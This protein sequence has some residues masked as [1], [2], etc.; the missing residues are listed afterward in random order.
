MSEE[1][2]NVPRSRK[3]R[4][5]RTARTTAGVAAVVLLGGIAGGAGYLY[6][7][8]VGEQYRTVFFPHTVVNGVDASQKTVDEVE[9][10]V[11]SRMEEDYELTVVGRGGVTETITGK[12]IGMHYE[13][14]DSLDQYLAAQNPMDWWS[15]R[16]TAVEYKVDVKA[17]PDEELLADR[18]D[19][20]VFLDDDKMVEP[21]NASLS[22]YIE[23]EGYQV[24]PEEEGTVLDKEKVK[25]AVTD[26][27][28][29]LKTE[30]VLEDLG[31]YKKA[32]VTSGDQSLTETADK[33]NRYLT[34]TV[35]YQF[36]DAQEILD[37]DTISG[38]IS[39]AEDGSILVDE[40]QAAAYV[41]GLAD[42]YDTLGKPKTLKTTGGDVVTITGGTFGWSINQEE[43]T[44]QLIEVIRS[45]E[46]Q[47]REPVY[48]ST[49]RSHGE[50]DYGDTYVEL[51]LTDQHMYYYKDGEMVLESDFVSGTRSNQNRATPTG[52]YFII[53]KQRDRVLR[54]ERRADG[55]YE[56]ESPV[57]YWMPF[58]GGVG[59]HDASWRGAFGGN[60][61]LTNGSHGCV[62]LPVSAAKE[63]YGLISEGDPVLVFTTDG[64][65]SS[66]Y[67]S[68]TPKPAADTAA[69][70]AIQ[71]AETQP[72]VTPP[73]EVQ[74][75]PE[76]PPAEV[77]PA[78][79]EP[80]PDE[81]FDE[82]EPAEDYDE[83]EESFG[84]VGSPLEE[85]EDGPGSSAGGELE[86]LEET[87]AAPEP[88][89][90]L[91]EPA[92][93]PGPGGPIGDPVEGSAGP[94]G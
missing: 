24:L 87:E 17:V 25:K 39:L 54:G 88:E 79:G 86:E 69:A 47:V 90:E 64:T 4:L 41:K 81:D 70:P 51:N 82:P 7:T 76:E 53:Y 66:T 49:A 56:Y 23:G 73:A 72:A 77:Q 57:S 13:F 92:P 43:E 40:E 15:Y 31:V 67:P 44:K 19:R 83:P 65:G 71:P 62:N 6:Y 52:A 93:S 10:L 74:P 45:G 36:G 60:I 8:S 37:K 80:E 26:A 18:I 68:S 1:E 12:E 29:N 11:S 38:W 55:S 78:P 50:N 3:R 59:L 14:D 2:K 21:K 32:A 46:S 75:A 35:T 5:S 9:Q 61:Y 34:V 30:L 42:R 84:P 58:V 20:L 28:H 63:L 85:E 89:P 91:S 27:V 48:S 16:S 33:L 94:I 22:E